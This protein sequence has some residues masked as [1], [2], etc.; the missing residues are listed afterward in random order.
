MHRHP[1][2]TTRPLPV[3]TCNTTIN[4]P[5]EWRLAVGKQADIRG[6]S[7]GELLK[8]AVE[9]FIAQD[10]PATAIAM[11]QSRGHRAVAGVGLA[12][13]G[14]WLAYGKVKDAVTMPVERPLYADTVNSIWMFRG[15]AR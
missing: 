15:G 2:P 10:Q 5:V 13:L 7:L 3:G 11:R 4:V 14:L 8:Q 6:L 1:L 9:H 12:L